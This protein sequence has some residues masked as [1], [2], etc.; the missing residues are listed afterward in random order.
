MRQLSALRVRPVALP[1]M[2]SRTV[3]RCGTASA[4]TIAWDTHYPSRV[5][6]SRGSVGAVV[7]V[8]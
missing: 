6:G 8:L 2:L 3:T 5:A 4:H 1:R 7:P